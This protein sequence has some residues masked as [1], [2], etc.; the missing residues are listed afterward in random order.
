MRELDLT[1]ATIY[2]Q[3]LQQGL[4]AEFEADFPEN[5]SFIARTIKGRRYWYYNGYDKLTGDKASEIRGSCRQSRYQRPGGTVSEPQVGFPDPAATRLRAQGSRRRHAGA[6][7]RRRRQ[8][9][10]PS[11]SI[12]ASLRPRRYR[13]VSILWADA[14][15]HTA[16]GNDEGRRFRPVSQ[17][18]RRDRRGRA[19]GARSRTVCVDWTRPSRRYRTGTTRRAPLPSS[20]RTVS[21][22]S[23]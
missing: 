5:G 1:V 14:R 2:T 22:S 4:D 8:C 16:S 17:C 19:A 18:L 15:G 3:L 21:R 11:R 13:R 10:S 12:P 7:H 23:S 9:T 20:T 6:I